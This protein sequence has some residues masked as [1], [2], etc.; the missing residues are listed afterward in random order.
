MREKEVYT[1]FL[2]GNL[3]ERNYLEGPGIDGRI[4]LIWIF[5]KWDVVIWTGS[6]LLKKWIGGWHL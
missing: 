2:W 4:I 1:E 5:G 3:K 6:M